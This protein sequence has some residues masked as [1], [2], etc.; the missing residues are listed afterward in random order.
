VCIHVIPL[1][2][3]DTSTNGYKDSA[4]SAKGKQ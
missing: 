2:D 1:A 3:A 4:A